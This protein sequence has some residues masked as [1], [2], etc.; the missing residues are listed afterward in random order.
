[1]TKEEKV[2]EYVKKY[3]ADNVHIDWREF[4]NTKV[5]GYNKSRYIASWLNSG[6]NMTDHRFYEW[7]LTIEFDDGHM[8]EEE[9]EEIVEFADGGKFEFER[10]AEQYLKT[11]SK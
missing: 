5:R 4:L 11:H 1:M 3:G 9:A 7:L 6:G 8:T 10:S 2:I